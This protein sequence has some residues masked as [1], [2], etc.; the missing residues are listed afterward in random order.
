M[1]KATSG[2]H[3]ERKL[4]EQVWEAPLGSKFRK[5]TWQANLEPT[6][7]GN[8]ESRFAN[9]ISEASGGNQLVKQMLEAGLERGIGKQS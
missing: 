1:L 6:V 3:M 4:G 7:E 5:R 8:I 9:H 2:H